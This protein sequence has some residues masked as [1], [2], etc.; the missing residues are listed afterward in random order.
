MS[1]EKL[2]ALLNQLN[3]VIVGKPRPG[4]GLRGLP[5]GRRPPAD[6]GRARRRQDHAGPCAVALLRPAVLARAVHRRPDAQ[7]PVRRVDLRARRRKVLCSTRAG[8]R[9]GAAG[10]RDQPR[11]PQDPERP[12]RS[13]GGKTGHR[14]RRNPPPALALFCDRHAKPA[15]PARHL[16][17]ARI[18]AGPLSTC[19]SRWATPTAPPSASCCAAPTGARWSSSCPALLAPHDLLELQQMVRQVHACGAAAQLPAGP[20]GA[21]PVRAAGSCRA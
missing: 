3:T 9:P 5:A 16:R 12:A 4:A 13:H 19:G 17:P 2:Q 14:R 18:A 6:R 1:Q 7:R 10:R 15:R 21:P 8:V 11:Q 20:D